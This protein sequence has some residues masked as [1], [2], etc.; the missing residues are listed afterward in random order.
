MKVNVANVTLH[1]S[2]RI[3]TVSG[4]VR[5]FVNLTRGERFT[6]GAY[7]GISKE[8]FDALRDIVGALRPMPNV[9]PNPVAT[10]LEILAL[11][12]K[13]E[14]TGMD[15]CTVNYKAAWVGNDLRARL[16]M[17]SLEEEQEIAK[18]KVTIGASGPAVEV[19]DDEEPF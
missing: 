3:S 15:T 18:A 14:C 5:W 4:N 16:G 1:V 2:E 17:P 19:G 13:A 9:Q 10:R 11:L 6:R 8:E 12:A 7:Q